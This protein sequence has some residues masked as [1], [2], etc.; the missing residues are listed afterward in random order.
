MW[1]IASARRSRDWSRCHGSEEDRAGSTLQCP[2]ALLMEGSLRHRHVCQLP[3][4]PVHL[5]FPRVTVN[6]YSLGFQILWLAIRTVIYNFLAVGNVRRNI[7]ISQPWEMATLSARRRLAA[8]MMGLAKQQITIHPRGAFA[9]QED[10]TDG[11]EIMKLYQTAGYRCFEAL[12]PPLGG[13]PS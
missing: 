12:P 13:I 2:A 3:I 8:L 11:T 7:M 9:Y 5:R 10:L 6:R 4:D 1:Y